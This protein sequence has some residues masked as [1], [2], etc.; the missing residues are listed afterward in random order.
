MRLIILGPP[1]AGKGSQAT[2]IKEKYNIVHI[3]TGDIFREHLR[4]ETELGK[5]AQVYMNKGQLVPDELTI[6]LVKDRLSQDDVKDGFLLDGFPRNLDQAAALTDFLKSRN[7]DLDAVV[8]L[9][10]D[11]ASLVDRI[12][13]R[14]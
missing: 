7:E 12:T 6:E 11:K 1:G 4:N 8:N 3:S 5:Q 9:N 10:V 14:R 2:F 13:G